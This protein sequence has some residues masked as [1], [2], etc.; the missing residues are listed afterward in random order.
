[1][2][3]RIG[4][5]VGR[6]ESV[7]NP[8]G[9]GGA[10]SRRLTHIRTTTLQNDFGVE[11]IGRNLE[12]FQRVFAGQSLN[13]IRYF[14]DRFDARVGSAHQ[15]METLSESSRNRD[16]E[17]ILRKSV[18]IHSE[19]RHMLLMYSKIA[20]NMQLYFAERVHEAISGTRCDHSAIIRILVARSEVST[21][22]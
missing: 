16:F 12:L 7:R 20:R 1:M 13:Q 10:R 17:S 5:G 19:V 18:N 14:L 21:Q 15:S 6:G 2:R 9:G 3:K 4:L 22:T 11:E 8:A